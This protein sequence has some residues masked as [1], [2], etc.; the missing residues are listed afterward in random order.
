MSVWELTLTSKLWRICIC[1]HCIIMKIQN[2]VRGRYHLPCSP[3]PLVQNVNCSQKTKRGSWLSGWS[4]KNIWDFIRGLLWYFSLVLTK[5]LRYL[6]IFYLWYN[7]LS[8]VETKKIPKIY[9]VKSYSILQILDI[10]E[11]HIILSKIIESQQNL[12]KTW[13]KRY[14]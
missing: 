6:V 14:I 4:L 9:S 5:I 10:F 8:F 3:M 12:I 2:S 1:T 11:K 13:Q 7:T